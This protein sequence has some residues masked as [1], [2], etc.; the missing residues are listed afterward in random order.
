MRQNFFRNHI[1]GAGSITRPVDQQSSALPLYHGC[2]CKD[3]R[4]SALQLLR[5]ERAHERFQLANLPN[6]KIFLEYCL[7][8]MTNF[9]FKIICMFNPFGPKSCGRG[10][11][12]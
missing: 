5:Q 4:K 7:C 3:S 6:K 10:P 2:L 1:P 12:H 11:G 8:T 9:S